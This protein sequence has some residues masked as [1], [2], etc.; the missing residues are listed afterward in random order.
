MKKIED[1]D[2][3]CICGHTRDFHYNPHIKRNEGSSACFYNHCSGRAY[4]SQDTMNG[5]RCT[6]FKQ[7]EQK[8]WKMKKDKYGSWC[9][10]CSKNGKN[11]KYCFG[12][13]INRF[14]NSLGRCVHCN[15]TV[16][17][18]G[19]K[20]KRSEKWKPTFSISRD[21]DIP[22]IWSSAWY[23]VRYILSG[24]SITTRRIKHG[25]SNRIGFGQRFNIPSFI[26][27]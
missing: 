5:C 13:L 27:L 17:S 18:R 9:M 8:E 24:I 25:N 14:G 4:T 10:I 3:V 15:L 11:Y 19:G 21:T 6:K 22:K 7:K 20:K 23:V 2:D 12:C 16:E 1:I 26:S